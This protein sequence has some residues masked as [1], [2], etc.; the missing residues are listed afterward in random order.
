MNP[1]SEV[2]RKIETSKQYISSKTVVVKAYLP[3]RRLS[4]FPVAQHAFIPGTK[5]QNLRYSD[6]TPAVNTRSALRLKIGDP[7]AR[8]RDR[9]QRL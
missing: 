2:T 8:Q 6:R 7:T 5:Q 3:L 4:Y 9:R 1:L